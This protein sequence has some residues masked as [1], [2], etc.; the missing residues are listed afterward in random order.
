MAIK[1]SVPKQF[2]L[3]IYLM[4]GWPKPLGAVAPLTPPSVFPG[5]SSSLKLGVWQLAVSHLSSNSVFPRDAEQLSH[6]L[7]LIYVRTSHQSLQSGT[8]QP[9]AA[10]PKV[11]YGTTSQTG[12][13]WQHWL[14][15]VTSLRELLQSVPISPFLITLHHRHPFFFRPINCQSLFFPAHIFSY[16]YFP[17]N[18]IIISLS[19][20]VHLHLK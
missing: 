14:L 20:L 7:L 10:S 8:E 9:S 1:C 16:Y 11:L 15:P 13:K 12:L 6:L 19:N 18:F 17:D 5:S 3:L 4:D 2:F